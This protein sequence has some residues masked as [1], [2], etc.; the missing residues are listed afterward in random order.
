MKRL[1][2]TYDG[3]TLYDNDVDE[4]V[5]TDRTDGVS[6]QG[7]LKGQSSSG[8]R[9]L[10]EMLAQRSRASTEEMIEQKRAELQETETGS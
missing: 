7:T 6:V 2:I 1:T 10:L 8:G 3:N 4:I 9:G 5:W